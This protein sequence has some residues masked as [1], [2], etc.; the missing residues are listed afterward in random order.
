MMEKKHCWLA[1]GSNLPYGG[2][3]PLQVIE[4]AITAL[5]DAG[6]DQT[7]VS[8]LYR[9]EPVPKSDQP[10]FINCVITG[11]THHKALEILDI[12]QSIERIFGRE[13][14]TRWG[15]R[16]LDIDIINYDHQI[17]PSLDE[18]RAVADH[19][20][21]STDMPKLVLPHP[22]MHQRAFVLRP[23]CDLVPGW[24]HPVYSRTATD[25]LSEQPEQD[26]D[27]VVAVEVK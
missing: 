9:T 22:F 13:R 3:E 19:V 6:L 8:G 26:R 15:A 1:L 27:S 12:C 20:D 24:S 4:A 2:M 25:L 17:Y 7:R 16:T 21:V 5:Q 11:K 10:D 23:L 18:W 14:S